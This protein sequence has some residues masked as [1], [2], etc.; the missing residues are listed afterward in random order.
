MGQQ[1]QLVSFPSVSVGSGK[2]GFFVSGRLQKKE[3]VGRVFF[4]LGRGGGQARFCTLSTSLGALAGDRFLGGLCTGPSVAPLP[5]VRS[6]HHLGQGDPP[7]LAQGCHLPLPGVARAAGC[8]GRGVSP[9]AW[10]TN[11]LA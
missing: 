1:V 9:S 4:S 5:D 8:R 10:A 7:N 3:I 11:P 2:S 6:G